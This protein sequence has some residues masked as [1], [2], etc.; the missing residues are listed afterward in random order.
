MISVIDSEPAGGLDLVKQVE[1]IFSPNGILSKSRN[2]EFRPQQQQMAI[3]VA[4]ALENREHLAVDSLLLV[5]HSIEDGRNEVG[6]TFAY[7]GAGFDG[8]V[9]A[10]FQR[11]SHGYG[12]L[13]LLRAE[14]E[15]SGLR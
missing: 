8:Q 12:H 6:K 14:L 5:G 1:E 7:T 15:I 9:L 11:A 13:L 3:A 2:F 4:R 10:I